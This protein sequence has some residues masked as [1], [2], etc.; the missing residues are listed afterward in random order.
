MSWKQDYTYEGYIV[1]F[2]NSLLEDF[3]PNTTIVSKAQ[4]WLERLK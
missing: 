1:E 2:L 3:Y 4:K